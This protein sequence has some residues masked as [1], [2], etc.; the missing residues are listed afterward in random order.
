MLNIL[1]KLSLYAGV[2]FDLNNLFIVQKK[3]A[4]VIDN[5][6]LVSLMD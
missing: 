4:V 3:L 6:S 1:L 2:F 5:C